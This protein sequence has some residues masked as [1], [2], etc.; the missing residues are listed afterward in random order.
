[1]APQVGFEPTTLRLTAKMSCSEMGAATGQ[2]Y[3][4]APRQPIGSASHYTLDVA[5]A[6]PLACDFLRRRLLLRCDQRIKLL[7]VAVAVREWQDQVSTITPHD[8][9]AS[10]AIA[11]HLER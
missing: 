8:I 5:S 7:A 2:L 10:Q 1:M 11:P 3:L 4:N 9:T 6:S